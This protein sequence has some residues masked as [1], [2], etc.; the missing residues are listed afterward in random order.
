M[1]LRLDQERYALCRLPPDAPDPPGRG[2]FRAVVRTPEEVSVACPEEDAPPGAVVEPGWRR[3]V[4]AGPL[5][6]TAVGVLASLAGAL[7]DAGVPV[8]ALSSY[9][10]DHLL[11]RHGDLSQAVAALE[12]AGH[13]VTRPT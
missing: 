8:F 10:T 13:R 3:L 7:A 4:V 12:A 9:D 6:L 5:P 2:S 11:V 1:E